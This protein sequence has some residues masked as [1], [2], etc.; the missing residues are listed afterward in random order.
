MKMLRDRVN[1]RVGLLGKSP[2]TLAK[3]VGLERGYIND[4]LIGRKKTIREGK[5]DQVAKALDC[6]PEYLLGHQEFA[7]ASDAR[8]NRKIAAPRATVQPNGLAVRGVCQSG[9]WR[10][11]STPPDYPATLPIAPDARYANL[12]QQAY[13][14]RPEETRTISLV[15]AID[16]P[17]FEKGVMPI[18]DGTV[19]VVQRERSDLTET[20]L[21]I[22]HLPQRELRPLD[23]D[24]AGEVI[25]GNSTGWPNDVKVLAVVT[26]LIR[27]RV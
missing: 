11:R 5:L 10:G 21:R 3:E 7:R 19:V 18:D 14:I 24:P 17:V 8:A 2:I 9:I 25:K 23:N 20:S 27:L 22:V 4:I 26:S 12:P 6:D 15:L 13:L 1:Q 16:L